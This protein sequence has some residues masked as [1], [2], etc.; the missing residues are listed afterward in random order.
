MI[1]FHGSRFAGCVSARHSV[2]PLGATELVCTGVVV[3]GVWVLI[4][5]GI[6]DAGDVVSTRFD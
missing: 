1:D 5:L 4:W 6:A 3:A 2:T